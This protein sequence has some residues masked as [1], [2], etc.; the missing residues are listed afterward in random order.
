MVPSD[1]AAFEANFRISERARLLESSR[2]AIEH[3]V[4]KVF[5][6]ILASEIAAVTVGELLGQN[7]RIPHYQRPYS[8]RPETA[9]QLLSDI[10]DSHRANTQSVY[11][12]G[13]VIL[14]AH[15]RELDVVDGQQRLL[16]LTLLLRLLSPDTHPTPFTPLGG[17]AHDAGA[18]GPSRAR[19]STPIGRVERALA[20]GMSDLHGAER[21]A[22]E[23]YVRGQCQLVKIVTDDADEAFRVFDSQNYRGRSLAPHDLLKAH[24]LREMQND[25]QASKAAVVE[26]W[27]SAGSDALDQLFSTYLYRIIKWSRGES[28]PGFT[29]HDIHMFKGISQRGDLMP[30]ERYHSAAQSVLPV[31]D[32]WHRAG[33]VTTHA[34]AQDPSHDGR[35]QHSHTLHS[36]FQ[37]DTPV[38]AGRAFFEMTEFLLGELRE[39]MSEDFPIPRS[40]ESMPFA[41]WSRDSYYRKCVELFIAAKLYYVNRFGH[42]HLRVASDALFA[43]AF[44]PRVAL[45]RVQ[46][47]SINKHARGSAE[48]PAAFELIRNGRDGRTVQALD[49]GLQL[50]D[51]GH[52]PELH[53]YLESIT[54]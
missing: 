51:P 30:S 50:P 41:V 9:L 19:A 25:S 11:V 27:E 53:T 22:L 52:V 4:R 39:F 10:R 1:A 32:A 29:T 38:L 2:A 31:L 12:L 17:A 36:R 15:D 28:A 24:H 16:T 48:T 3:E 37:L 54:S 46:H 5:M 7:L 34:H 26:A 20:L 43:W 13:S 42:E 23:D 14:H 33:A 44:S 18:N 40:G 35:L 6:A 49:L 47:A 8:W 21:A 45:L